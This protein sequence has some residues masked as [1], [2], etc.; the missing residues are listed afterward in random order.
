MQ[1]DQM[2]EALEK[3]GYR[4]VTARDTPDEQL[5]NLWQQILS[6]LRMAEDIAGDGAH[7]TIGHPPYFAA[8]ADVIELTRSAVIGKIETIL[9]NAVVVREARDA[10]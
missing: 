3:E 4:V 5:R 8:T 9:Q 2:I 10:I 7:L 1:T 6:L